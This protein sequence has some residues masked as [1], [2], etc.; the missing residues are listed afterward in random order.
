MTISPNTLDLHHIALKKLNLITNK[1]SQP[2]INVR[3][4]AAEK[5][6]QRLIFTKSI[7]LFQKTFSVSVHP[8]PLN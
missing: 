7:L 8:I 5:C 3:N 2:K 4:H 6:P 1:R